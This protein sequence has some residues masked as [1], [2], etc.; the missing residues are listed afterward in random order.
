MFLENIYW[1][2][3]PKIWYTNLSTIYFSHMSGY[4]FEG[5]LL[6]GMICHF[7][8]KSERPEPLPCITE[9][10]R[11]ELIKKIYCVKSP[12]PGNIFQLG[13]PWAWK[14]L[15]QAYLMGI[16]TLKNRREL[17]LNKMETIYIQWVAIQ[18][19]CVKTINAGWKVSSPPN[20]SK[21]IALEKTKRKLFEFRILSR[22]REKHLW[23]CSLTFMAKNRTKCSFPALISHHF[24]KHFSWEVVT[25]QLPFHQITESGQYTLE[26]KW[27]T[28]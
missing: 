25:L 17:H 24:S 6:K 18:R 5:I 26:N 3:N 4:I 15:E 10:T 9:I 7:C 14:N 12:T 1:I 16:N 8:I 20:P 11:T 13:I 19:N 2:N 22:N 23:S 27:R 21:S 28:A